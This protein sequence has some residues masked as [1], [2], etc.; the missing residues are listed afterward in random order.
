[1]VLSASCRIFSESVEGRVVTGAVDLSELQT[2]SLRANDPAVLQSHC[3]DGEV[4]V[5]DVI[6]VFVTTQ[7]ILDILEDS[8]TS[9]VTRLQAVEVLCEESRQLLCRRAEDIGVTQQTTEGSEDLVE[10]VVTRATRAY[11]HQV[12]E[13]RL[14][15]SRVC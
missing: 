3:R 11:A 1:P 8:S 12:N 6:A 5:D 10:R 9:G 4:R 2:T 15:E 7:L 13:C 14:K